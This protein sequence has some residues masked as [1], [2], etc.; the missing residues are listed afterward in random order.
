MN[1]KRR[2]APT[3]GDKPR[4]REV[5]VAKD[6][7]NTLV[8]TWS[9]GTTRLVDVTEPIY[10]LKHFRALRQR[11]RFHKVSVGDWGWSITWGDDLDLSNDRLLDL[12]EAQRESAMTP[13]HLRSWLRRRGMTQ[14][15]LAE[16]LG[17]SKRM[18]AYYSTGEQPITRLV[19][20]AV[21]GLERIDDPDSR[22]M[23]RST[24]K[25]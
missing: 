20:L 16:R 18:V 10:R 14:A 1:A 23:A 22:A 17:I 8:V 4:I 7:E 2:A 9:D 12:A 5:R 15:A 19:A 6:R 25:H 13:G 11:D 3:S 21:K 24:R